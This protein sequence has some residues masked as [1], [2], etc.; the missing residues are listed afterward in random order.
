MYCRHD[1]VDCNC[2][3][4]N[5]VLHQG[6]HL[7]LFS[8]FFCGLLTKVSSR[9]TTSSPA[10]GKGTC[11]LPVVAYQ[12]WTL[13]ICLLLETGMKLPRWQSLANQPLVSYRIVFAVRFREVCWIPHVCRAL[14]LC[15]QCLFFTLLAFHMILALKCW[16]EWMY[17]HLVPIILH[18]GS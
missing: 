5:Y 9:R 13:N 1:G 2:E 8:Y 12:L 6:V 10:F 15:Y 16:P 18:T 3:S 17:N 4:A 11:N 7:S 14:F